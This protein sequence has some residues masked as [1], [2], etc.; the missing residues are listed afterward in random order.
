M[1]SSDLPRWVVKLIKKGWMEHLEEYKQHCIDQAVTILTAGHDVKCMFA[2]PKLL[3]GLAQA[4]EDRGTGIPEGHAEP[5]EEI[6]DLIRRFPQHATV[7]RP[8]PA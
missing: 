3:E 8:C 5:C 4:L 6:A 7:S 1:C 2:T